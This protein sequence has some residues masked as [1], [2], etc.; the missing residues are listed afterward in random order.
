MDEAC[1]SHRAHIIIGQ[2][3]DPRRFARQI[4]HTPRVTRQVRG[5]Q[6]DQIGYRLKDTVQVRPCDPPS[7]RRLGVQQ[8]IPVRSLVQPVQQLGRVLA[9]QVH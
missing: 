2:A 9:E 5:L 3:R 1:A 8:R 7:E 4:G 6:V